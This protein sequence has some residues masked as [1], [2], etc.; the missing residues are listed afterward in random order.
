MQG[1]GYINIFDSSNLNPIAPDFAA[2]RRLRE[3]N[4]LNQ[5]T[6]DEHTRIVTLSEAKGLSER[7]FAEFILSLPKGS[8]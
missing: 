1:I 5:T 8:A 7:C 4:H 3:Y 2:L 6:R